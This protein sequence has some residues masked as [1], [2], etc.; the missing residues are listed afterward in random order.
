M[1]NL[2]ICLMTAGLLLS[3]AP[4]NLS[5]SASTTPTPMSA[6]TSNVATKSAA[7]TARLNEINEMDKSNM[8][9]SEKKQLRKEARSTKQELRQLNGGVYISAGAV[10]LILILLIVLL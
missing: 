8:A 10:I 4:K 6:A 3:F 1:K 9:S 2:T 5:A 7:L